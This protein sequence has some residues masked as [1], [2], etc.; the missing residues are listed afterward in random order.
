MNGVDSRHQRGGAYQRRDRRA[1]VRGLHSIGGGRLEVRE[2]A[3]SC[4]NFNRDERRFNLQERGGSHAFPQRRLQHRGFD[5]VVVHV[6]GRAKLGRRRVHRR[7]R[8]NKG[9]LR[10]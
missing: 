4:P 7:V 8:Q 6:G 5:P 2:D 1:I 9:G 3:V 10:E